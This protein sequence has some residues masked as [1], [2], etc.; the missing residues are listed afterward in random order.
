MALAVS[1]LIGLA[2]LI[3]DQLLRRPLG[4][5]EVEYAGGGSCKLRGHVDFRALLAIGVL[6][7]PAMIF[8]TGSFAASVLRREPRAWVGLLASVAVIGLL[9]QLKF[10]GPALGLCP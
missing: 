7:F 9:I 1:L 6:T 2:I 3:C 5:F 10:V 4:S 8:S